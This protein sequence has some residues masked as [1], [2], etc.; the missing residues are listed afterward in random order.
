MTGPASDGYSAIGSPVMKRRVALVEFSIYDQFPLVSGYLHAY[1]QADPAVADAFEFVY[2]QQEISRVDYAATLSALRGLGASVLCISCYVWNMGLVRRLVRDLRAD[3]AIERIILGGHQ[4]TNHAHRYLDRTDE[5]S[6]VINGQGEIPFRAM[7]Q[8]MSDQGD[9]SG[10]EGVSFYT[11]G[12]LFSGGEARML[13]DLEAIPSPFLSGY[14]DRE[15]HPVTVFETNR[16]C[17]FKC[18]FCT[19]GGD[20]TKVT[21]FSLERIKDE[22]DWIARR[23][24]LFIYLADANW[25]MLRRDVEISE[26]IARLKRERGFPWMVYYAAAKN[27]PDGSMACIEKFHAGGVITSQA[28]GIQSM[29]QPTLDLIDRKNIKNSAYIEM[30][31]RLA[32][33][34][35]DSYCELIWPLPGETLDTLVDGFERLVDLGA[36]TVIMYPAMLINNARLTSQAGEHA[37]ETIG[38]DDWKSE[39]RLVK[40]TRYADRAAVDEGFRLY[41]S[42]FLLANCDPTKALVRC[43]RQATGMRLADLLSGF[44]GQLRA[45]DPLSPYGRLVQSIFDEE[46][47]GSLLTIGRI[48]AHLSHEQRFAA[49]VD[50]S[51]FIASQLPGDPV[52]GLVLSGLWCLCLPRLFA[53][54]ADR[55]ADLVQHLDQLAP[56]ARFSD[57]AR[58]QSTRQ[59]T[60]LEV[61]GGEE[62]WAEVLRFFTGGEVAS[63]VRTIE[64]AHSPAGKLPHN[65]T[66][67]TRNFIYAHGM[68]QR[69]GFVAAHLKLLA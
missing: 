1:A 55:T 62:V 33:R 39:L 47:H 44:A 7:L 22:L 4:I 36:R 63:P 26:H 9:L 10:L 30:F 67:P 13:A 49:Q 27:Q 61:L 15:K 43:L 14:F 32:A 2:Y 29:N 3:P 28:L 6:I 16:G 52:R 60:S 64:I 31:E 56:G 8:R 46:A 54:T 42:H 40:C 34:G 18:T 48:A 25:G 59:A 37:M 19:W 53:D 17:P 68:V 12:E 24:V 51:R 21:R 38:S 45:A 35:I 66:D 58:V 23:S 41:Y 5:K 65:A 69:L 50:A 11:G 57:L 20:T